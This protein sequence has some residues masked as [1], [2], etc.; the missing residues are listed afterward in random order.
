MPRRRG[1]SAKA[2]EGCAASGTESRRKGSFSAAGPG[3]NAFHRRRPMRW[4][5]RR[6]TGVKRKRRCRPSRRATARH[7]TPIS[8]PHAHG[9]AFA[10]LPA[11]CARIA[12]LLGMTE[13]KIWSL[14]SRVIPRKSPYPERPFTEGRIHHLDDCFSDR[15]SVGVGR[16]N[17]TECFQY[18]LAKALIGARFVFGD[19]CFIRGP[20]RAG[21]PWWS[22]RETRPRRPRHPAAP[23]RR[24]TATGGRE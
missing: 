21:M 3:K 19:A 13:P 14:F 6:Q 24:D 17:G 15:R 12:D 11:G 2:N 16:H 18:L 8:G 23:V 20:A 5:G 9:R 1:P 10:A 22:A 7:A 4:R